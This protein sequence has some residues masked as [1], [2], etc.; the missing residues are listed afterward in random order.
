MP[1]WSYDDALAYLDAHVDYEALASGRFE[2]PNLE[3]MQQLCALSGAPQHAQPALHLTGTN[4]KGSTA[5]MAT[6]L[7]GAHGLKVGTYTSPDLG[8]VNERLSLD[9]VPIDDEAFADAIAAVAGLEAGS[10]I[11]PTRFEILTLAALRW[12]AEEAVDVAVVEVGMGGRWDAT[13]VVDATV[14]VVTNVGLDHTGVLGATRLRI[15]GEKS[16]IVKPASTLV[17]GETDP[18]LAA[19]FDATGPAA[20]WRRGADFDCSANVVAVGGRMLDLRTPGAS[21]EQVFL[22]LHGE[23]QGDNAAAALAAVEAFFGRPVDDDVLREGLAGVAVP[24]R[25]EVVGRQ[26]LVVLD[27]AHNPDGCRAAAR[28]LD[29]FSFAGGPVLVVGMNR[30]RSATEMLAALGVERARLVVACSVDWPRALPAEEVAV[31]ARRLGAE[32]EAVPDVP[33]ALRRAL[34][35]AT[36]DDAVLVTGSLYV[37]GA[38]RPLLVS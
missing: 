1:T 10:G 13:N 30:G 27:G 20:T 17:L 16:G 26:P 36:S 28:T 21:Y 9:G 24:G 7:L 2:A 5:R 33:E 3:R 38:A 14:A 15:A 29:D 4:G 35:V 23:H 22:P 11:R 25:F 12:F 8:R 6:A 37:V 19:V 18:E 32:A 34:G 31:A